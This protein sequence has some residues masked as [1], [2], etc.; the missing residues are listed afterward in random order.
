MKN[1]RDAIAI[2]ATREAN[3]PAPD[4]EMREEQVGSAPAETA[5]PFVG[6][7]ASRARNRNARDWFWAWKYAP[8]VP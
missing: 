1:K 6:G 8:L 4:Y 2:A 7:L 5:L 3:G